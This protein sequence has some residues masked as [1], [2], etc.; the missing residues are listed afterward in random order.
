M[1][2]IL[3]S[4]PVLLL[5]LAQIAHGQAPLELSQT[6]LLPKVV[7]G[8]NHHSADAK[9]H[10]LFVCATTNKTVEVIDLDSGKVI[11]TISGEKPSATCFAPELN[12]LCVSHSKGIR[13]YN[14]DT[15]EDAG[16]LDLSTSIDE[17][18][19][20]SRNQELLVGCMSAPSKGIAAVNLVKRIVLEKIKTPHPQGFTLE[21]DGDRVF[22]CTPGADQISVVDRKKP[23]QLEPWKLS[24]VRVDYSVAYDSK[25]HRLFVGCRRPAKLLVFDTNTGKQVASAEI[26]KDTDDLSFDSA[27]KRVYV[28]CGEGVIS[29]IQQEGPDHYRNIAN[30]PTAQG[31]RNCIFLPETGEFCVTVPQNGEQPAKVLVYKARK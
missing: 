17:M 13:L 7:G 19:Y 1:K 26:G 18:H 20:D 12:L 15:F 2:R 23:V 6:I 27:N 11:K 10:H 25:T 28:A 30:V 3:A 21:D 24:D 22:V 29:V 14:A 9:R 5:G 31:A 4:L 8:F 16:A